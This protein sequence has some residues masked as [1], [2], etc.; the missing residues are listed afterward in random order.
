MT[1]REKLEH[2]KGCE[3]RN[4]EREHA[5]LE[6]MKAEV[7][8]IH[9]MIERYAASVVESL[10]TLAEYHNVP[11]GELLE[12]LIDTVQALEQCKAQED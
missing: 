7:E 5:H 9:L 1:L 3:A 8:H 2:I 6:Q 11:R 10:N 12:L 4:L